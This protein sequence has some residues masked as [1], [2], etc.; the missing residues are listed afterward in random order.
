[1][2]QKLLLFIAFIFT[3]TMFLQRIAVK[4]IARDN[5]SAVI[6]ATELTFIFS[7]TKS[8]GLVLFAETENIRIDDFG[9]FSYIVNYGDPKVNSFDEVNF[10]LENLELKIGVRYDDNDIEVHKGHFHYTP[11]AHFAKF[12]KKVESS[13]L[14]V[15]AEIADLS[16]ALKADDGLPTGTVVAFVDA[17]ASVG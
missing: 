15:I 17:K 6:T 11:Y 7:I 1:M 10:K 12:A 3:A 16:S 9:V 4:G 5:A 13:G 2:K 14:A 8:D